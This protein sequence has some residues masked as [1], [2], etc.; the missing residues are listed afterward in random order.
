VSFGLSLLSKFAATSLYLF[1]FFYLYAGYLSNQYSRNAF[2]KKSIGF[3]QVLIISW[4]L[5]A[6]LYP[7]M[8]LHPQ[9]IFV[10]TIGFVGDKIWYILLIV[11]IAYIEAVLLKGRIS[12][13]FRTKISFPRMANIIIS[14]PLFLLSV[15]LLYYW[16][17]GENTWSL[18]TVKV[19]RGHG[20]FLPTLVQSIDHMLSEISI[21]ALISLLIFLAISGFKIAE[22]KFKEDY[23]LMT[24]MLMSIVIY[25]AGA[26]MQGIVSHGRYDILLFPIFAFISGSFYLRLFPKPKILIPV[27]LI[28]ALI[29]IVLFTPLS[30]LDY[31]NDKYFKEK[32]RYFSWGMGGYE[33]A[34]KANQLPNA[35][36]LKVLSDYHGFGHFFIGNNTFMT[37]NNIISNDYIKK[38]DYLCL[39]S[40]GRAQKESWL[41]MTNSLRQYYDQPLEDAVFHIG[42]LERG[43]FKFVKVDKERE[44]LEISGCYDPKFFICLSKPFTIGFWLRTDSAK[45]GNPI[46]IG[47][48][49]LH[50]ISL[51]WINEKDT[52]KLELRYNDQDAVETPV[53]N[54]GKWHHILFRQGGGKAGKKVSLFVDGVFLSSFPLSK[55]K[56]SIEKFFINT[57]FAGHL[58]DFRIYDQVLTKNQI[59]AIFNNGKIRLEKKLSD[60]KKDFSPVNHFLITE[61]TSK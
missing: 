54:D 42:S 7:A 26:S 58:Q 28:L 55:E 61:K 17:A 5:Y 6:L 18:L 32:G 49:S 27:F 44:G 46:Y 21:P 23:Y 30:Y 25:K 37:Q 29:D 4:V 12:D 34:Q 22:K 11:A 45:P 2:L 14:F 31:S 57:K 50:G 60:G 13:S 48:N 33:L 39:S 10:R 43:Y 38:F 53:I 51:D 9:M 52:A 41:W 19:V 8:L 59:D 47:K 40:N 24:L 3:L 16:F 36:S 20:A 35:E 15:V 56:N 1:F